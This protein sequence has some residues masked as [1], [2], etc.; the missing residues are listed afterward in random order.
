[1]GLEGIEANFLTTRLEDLVKWARR[2]SIWP[3]TFGLAFSPLY[4]LVGSS[5]LLAGQWGS[6][7]ANGPDL[8]AV[9]VSIAATAVYAFH[10]Q[11]RAA[12]LRRAIAE[13]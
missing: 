10:F 5:V 12:R 7:G 3:A 6:A 2:N 8:A 1:M 11:R 13:Q 4:A 9:L